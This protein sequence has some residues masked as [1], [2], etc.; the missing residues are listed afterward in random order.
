MQRHVD[1]VGLEASCI[2]SPTQLD[3]LV[4]VELGRVAWPTLVDDRQLGGALARLVDQARVLQRDAEAR[5]ERRR[6]G[7]RRLAE[8]V[9]R[10]RFWRE[11]TPE[12]SPPMTER[13]E[14]DDFG[15]FALDGFWLAV[16]RARRPAT[17]SSITTV[18]RRLEDP[19]V[20][21]DE[22]DRRRRGKRTPRS[23]VYGK[24]MTSASRVV[25][26]DVDD[27]GVEDLLDLVADEVVHRLHVELCG[28]ALLDAVDDRQLGGALVGL[29]QQALRLVEQPRVLEGDAQAR[30][31]RRQQAHVGFAERVLAVE[32]LEQEDARTSPPTIS[33]T[34]RIDLAARPG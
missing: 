23:I 8:G 21:A 13:R 4:E 11:I 24:R 10:S 7:A 25:D 15:G 19:C 30:C 27:L 22:R 9:S 29:G 33:G 3:Q 1:D 2:W 6:A 5:G 18:A 14:D 12:T 31:E 28:E 26:A 34:N 32:V 17:S 16:G 20:G